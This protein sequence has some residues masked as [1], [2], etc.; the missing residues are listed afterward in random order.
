MIFNIPCLF[1][2]KDFDQLPYGR[3][4]IVGDQGVTLSGVK[5]V[6]MIKFKL[7]NSVE[8]RDKNLESIWHVHFIVM[9]ISTYW[10]TLFQ[11]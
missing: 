1:C 4:T 5:C 7:K 8:F 9:P 6:S 3:N 2:H 11:L 10:M